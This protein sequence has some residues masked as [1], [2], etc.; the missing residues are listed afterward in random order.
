[1][2]V[3]NG[4]TAVENQVFCIF[5]GSP[6]PSFF[7]AVPRFFTAVLGMPSFFYGIA[8]A[9]KIWDIVILTALVIP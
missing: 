3:E 1:M 7:T 5:Y 2:P 8:N 4:G 9:V 6:R